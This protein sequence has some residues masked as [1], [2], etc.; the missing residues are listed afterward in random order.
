LIENGA[1]AGQRVVVGTLADLPER[2]A[3][4]AVCSPALLI[5]GEVAGLATELAWFGAVPIAGPAIGPA[6]SRVAPH[7]QPGHEAVPCTA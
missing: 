3:A 2:A 7:P 5:L 4:H 6:V 1:R